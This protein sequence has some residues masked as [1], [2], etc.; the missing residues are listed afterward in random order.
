MT[1]AVGDGRG[2]TALVFGVSLFRPKW[3]R[4]LPKLILP[5]P[6]NANLSME[7]A[8]LANLEL[9]HLVSECLARPG[10]I[11]VRL[12]RDFVDGKRRSGGEIVERARERDRDFDR[13]CPSDAG[14]VSPP[15][16]RLPSF[17]RGRIADP[18]QRG[19]ACGVRK[20]LRRVL[21][22]QTHEQS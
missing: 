8:E 14:A 17:R 9:A 12:G 21:L 6:F 4:K 22:F 20:D 18:S 10:D 19:K 1:F 11:A 15:W 16:L 3:Q 2:V 7:A 13:G 5:S